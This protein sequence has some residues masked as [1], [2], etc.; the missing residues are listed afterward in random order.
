MILGPASLNFMYNYDPDTS[1]DS[2]IYTTLYDQTF[3]WIP[4]L[5]LRFWMAFSLT[6]LKSQ[7]LKRRHA[8]P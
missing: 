4:R 2:K 7:L 3:N 1:S 8:P 5:F 6:M